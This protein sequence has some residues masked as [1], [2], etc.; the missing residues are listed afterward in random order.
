MAAETWTTVDHTMAH[1]RRHAAGVSSHRRCERAEGVTL[2]FL[3]TVAPN[4]RRSI[5]RP[6]LQAPVVSSDPVGTSNQDCIFIAR[7]ALVEAE[8]Q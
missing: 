6:N 1:G 5:G 8:L 4:Q 3:D 2:R 7:S